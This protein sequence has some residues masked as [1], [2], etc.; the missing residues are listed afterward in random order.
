MTNKCY[1]IW[2][3]GD[4]EIYHSMMLNLRRQEF[5]VD[6]PPFWKVS[7]PSV[8]V[9]FIKNFECENDGYMTA[10]T[11]GRG[12]MIVDGKRYAMNTK[13]D[14]KA[15]KHSVEAA[16]FKTDGLPA[17]YVDSDV[18]PSDKSW[19][20]NH[21]AGK[22][23]NAGYDEYF[24]SLD[25]DPEVFPFEYER[26]DPISIEKVEDGILYDFGK[27][28]F[29]F[30]NIS[31]ADEKERLHVSYGESRE[32]ALDL[33][34]AIIFETVVGKNEY[35]L[36]QR[37]F[38]YIFIKGA[39]DKLCVNM[40]YEYLPF[41]Q[42]GS[43]ACDNKTFNDVYAA[44]VYTFH[45]N[46]REGF[47]D[48]IKRDRWIWSGD[49]YQSARIN[50]Y[51]FADK[52]I[53]QRTAIGLVG[54]EPIEQNLNTIIDY[55]FLWMI[56]L[57]EYYMT[58]GDAEFIVRMY[59]MAQKLMDFC[60]E[61]LNSDG[62]VEGIKDDWTFIDWSKI[63]KTGAVCAEQMLLIAA[64]SV[65]ARLAE[66]I[67]QDGSV[68]FGKSE[69]LKQKVNEF[70]WNEE[71]GAF[72][73]SYVSGKNN[74]TRHANIFAVM[75]DIATEEQTKSI[76]KNVLKND[77]IVKIT[78][79]YFKGYEL[80]VLGKVGE[81]DEL[82]DMIESYWGEMLK[83]GATTIW[84]EFDPT[85]SGTQHYAMYG[86]KYAKSLCHAWGAGPVYLFGRYY[87]GVYPSSAGFETFN[88]EP[89]LGGLEKIEG[90]VP[91]NEGQVKIFCDGKKLSVLATKSGGT[92]IWNGQKY[93]LEPNVELVI[94]E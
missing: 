89:R 25:K 94:E 27:E 70:Y 33:D 73:D 63:D 44:C 5:G 92:L 31:G 60:E 38:R 47:L 8:T 35:R 84:E 76:V 50:S 61:R 86:N 59:P 88:V 43:F 2:K 37:A 71:K 93:P 53:V 15:G 40:D 62:F 12:Y 32:E 80:D 51:L 7:S 4:Y 20:C 57:Y 52:N 34:D 81:F 79:P 87:L 39:N 16:I 10:N 48:G 82:E 66:V 36:T 19:L 11:N 72:I 67:G 24:D 64:Y 28:L 56:G 75:Y 30:L 74:V 90:T 58:Y 68:Y 9:K 22:F 23:T 18:C 3:Y 46:C 85:L 83:L 45:L 69:K 55:S 41:K 49:A 1:W 78:T 6:Y 14:V 91:A 13:I 21:H 77:D 65:M 26:K 42:K 17:L 29:G 54:K